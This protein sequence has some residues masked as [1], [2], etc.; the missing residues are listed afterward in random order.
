MHACALLF[1]G[2]DASAEI[3]PPDP[4]VP[5]EPASAPV[6]VKRG[7][8]GK[9]N[10]DYYRAVVIYDAET[11]GESDEGIKAIQAK[12]ED[13][14][15]SLNLLIRKI[16]MAGKVDIDEKTAEL[17]KLLKPEK[18]PFTI[19]YFPES[20]DI[21]KPLWT[22]R[23]TLEEAGMI[24]DS[25]ARREIAR[26]LLKGE[27]AVWLLIESAIE[28]KD[29]KVLKLIMEEINGIRGNPSDNETALPPETDGGKEKNKPG[30]QVKMSI[31]RISRDDVSEKLLLNLLNDIEPE[32]MNVSNEPVLVPIYARGR[33]LELLSD[34]EINRDNIRSTVEFLAGAGVD[35]EKGPNPGT[36][37]LLSVNWDGFASGKLSVDE[38]LPALRE[39]SGNFSLD[40]VFPSENLPAPDSELRSLTADEEQ[41]V[42][43]KPPFPMTIINIVLI[44][45]IGTL[46]ALFFVVVM[47]SRK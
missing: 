16:D 14:I 47:R 12:T 10:P 11:P 25:P 26:R 13:K 24:G 38:E 30:N 43:A 8:L 37:L 9:S 18:Y 17:L 41:A 7:G 2:L 21:E 39:Y 29:Y 20:S 32:I 40:G 4:S 5:V 22:G 31:I 15:K 45:V 34:D 36:S 6:A 23:M 27:S 19:I 1:T 33:I 46:I 3:S 44:S 28:Y 42:S 35:R